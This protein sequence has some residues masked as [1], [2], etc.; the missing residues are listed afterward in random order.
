MSDS[1][2]QRVIQKAV[3]E[4]PRVKNPL[5][6]RKQY[7]LEKKLQVVRET[8][9]PR[10]SV[11]VV[12]RRHDINSNVVFRWRRE[13]A[14][15]ELRNDVGG[16]RTLPPP[17]FVPVG[18]VGPPKN[19]CSAQDQV[20]SEE[21]G[22]IEVETAAGVKIRLSGRVDDRVLSLVTSVI[23]TAFSFVARLATSGC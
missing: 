18:I 13:Y 17:A 16:Q 23:S 8:L 4:G 22:V 15:G 3:A 9:T 1:R 7:S 20:R 12:A 10:A 19:D 5:P 21:R 2:E 6:P 11:S 14:V